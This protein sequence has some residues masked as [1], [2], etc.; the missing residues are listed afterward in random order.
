MKPGSK[1]ISPDSA[2]GAFFKAV[3]IAYIRTLLSMTLPR[4]DL[5]SDV[6][7]AL[8]NKSMDLLQS[9]QKWNLNISFL[10]SSFIVRLQFAFLAS[11][12]TLCK[13]SNPEALSVIC[14]HIFFLR[15]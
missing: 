1:R 8:T 9:I 12:S 7:L 14:S 2:S 13:K 3:L 4:Q 10:V 6:N 15:L 11:I 5:S